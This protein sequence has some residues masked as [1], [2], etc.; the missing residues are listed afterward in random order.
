[1]YA[2]SIPQLLVVNRIVEAAVSVNRIQSFLL[3]EDHEPVPPGSL[4]TIGV[5]MENVTAAYESKKPRLDGVDLD[6]KT[7]EVLDKQWEVSL[8]KSQLDEAEQHIRQLVSEKQQSSSKLQDAEKH[9]KNMIKQSKKRAQ[10]QAAR[11]RNHPSIQPRQSADDDNDEEEWEALD[12]DAEC[13]DPEQVDRELLA[14]ATEYTQEAES[15]STNEASDDGLVETMVDVEGS[16]PSSNTG[17][18]LLCLKRVNFSCKE[19]ELV[20]VVGFVGSGKSTIVNSILGEVKLLSGTSAVRGSLAYF[21]QA[22]FIMNATIRDNI[23]FGHVKDDVID[24]ERYQKALDCCALRHD[25]KL[26][27]HGDQ[28]EIGERGVTLSGKL[29]EQTAQYICLFFNIRDQYLISHNALLHLL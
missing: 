9:I 19:G 6:P 14:Q 3:C 13:P 4:E 22:P 5:Q 8:L 27:S 2:L 20:A 10:Q 15:V 24:E 12:A 11:Q 1:M 23:L 26:L 18:N 25:L 28:T 21:S 7:K 16:V 29:L 17:G